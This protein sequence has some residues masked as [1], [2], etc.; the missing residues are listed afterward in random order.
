MSLDD[1]YAEWIDDKRCFGARDVI[2]E[3][4]ITL[5]AERITYQDS[6]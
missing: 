2:L 4:I 5:L 6:V 3:R 1:R